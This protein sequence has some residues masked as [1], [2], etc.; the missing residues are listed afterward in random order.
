M[1]YQAFFVGSI[2]KYKSQIQH[3]FSL[4]APSYSILSAAEDANSCTRDNT[5]DINTETELFSDCV[6][7]STFTT[8]MSKENSI[9]DI[10]LDNLLVFDLPMAM[11]V[12]E[13]IC[14]FD[15]I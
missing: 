7:A 11:Q 1:G 4:S 3:D 6:R 14:N 9:L 13:D 12:P 8:T 15:S 10:V 5:R 2:E